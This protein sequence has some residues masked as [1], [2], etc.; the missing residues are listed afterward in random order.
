[1]VDV[2]EVRA[3]HPVWHSVE[4][5]FGFPL[6]RIDAYAFLTSSAPFLVDGRGFKSSWGHDHD[7]ELDAVER[8]DDLQPP[9]APAFEAYTILPERNVLS[10]QPLTQLRSEWLPIIARIGE[11]DTW[12]G[13][14]VRD[15][16]SGCCHPVILLEVIGT[17]SV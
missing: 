4:V 15:C 5:R 1:M 7:H 6:D 2:I 16:I 14:S 9:V 3:A 17:S 13:V 11:K 10:F 12:R 8:L